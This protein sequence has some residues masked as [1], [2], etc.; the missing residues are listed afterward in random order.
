MVTERI[1]VDADP[2]I[3]RK[4]E[5]LSDFTGKSMKRIIVDYIEMDYE[6]NKD[7]I[8]KRVIFKEQREFPKLN[9]C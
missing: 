4:L 6:K 9:C 7:G 5:L 8:S 1:V 2:A 3:K